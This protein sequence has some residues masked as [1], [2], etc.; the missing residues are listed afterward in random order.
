MA[1]QATIKGDITAESGKIGFLDVDLNSLT[2]GAVEDDPSDP[3]T[4]GMNVVNF[5]ADR[6]LYRINGDIRGQIRELAY[7]LYSNILGSFVTE[8]ARTTN[9]IVNNELG[10]G[11]NVA[12]A[13]SAKNADKNISIDIIDGEVAGL[14]LHTR[15]INSNETLTRR[16]VWV[17]S[18][19]TSPTT[20]TLPASP[21]N[22]KVLYIRQ[23]NSFGITFNGNGINIHVAGNVGTTYTNMNAN[24]GDCHQFVYDGQFWCYN[25]LYREVPA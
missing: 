25:Q 13:F 7:N 5:Y 23:M 4:P 3:W 10:A 12:H 15:Q 8:A 2:L 22:G 11:V 17:S 16:D 21:N 24:I 6:F 9:S 1:T 18:Y 20:V 19:N 14:N